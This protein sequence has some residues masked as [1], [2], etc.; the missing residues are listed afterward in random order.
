[1]KFIRA[2]GSLELRAVD[3]LTDERIRVEQDAVVEQDV[4]NA[5]DLAFTQ[6]DVVEKRRAAIELHVEPVM[7]VVVK[8]GARGDDPVDETGLDERNEAGLAKPG[9]HEGA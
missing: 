1:M 3:H 7:D 4:V 6:F 8:V 2:H 9:G 5:D